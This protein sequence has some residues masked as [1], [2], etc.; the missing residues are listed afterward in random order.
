MCL[1]PH[2]ALLLRPPDFG[3][4]PGCA[5]SGTPCKAYFSAVPRLLTWQCRCPDSVSVKTVQDGAPSVSK[6]GGRRGAQAGQTDLIRAHCAA[7]DRGLGEGR[8]LPQQVQSPQAS[9][10][11]PQSSQQQPSREVALEDTT[12]VLSLRGEGKLSRAHRRGGASAWAAELAD[13]GPRTA[14]YLGRRPG[15]SSELTGGETRPWDRP[16]LRKSVSTSHC[17]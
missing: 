15:S 12:T 17:S 10:A 6:N 9:R 4:G 3:L 16:V 8:H 11:T 13:S 14:L 2:A 1:G 5:D 7:M